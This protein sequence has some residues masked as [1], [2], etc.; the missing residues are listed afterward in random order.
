MKNP[1]PPKTKIIAVQEA[2][3][4]LSGILD[5]EPTD[6]ELAQETG[7][8]K[9][10]IG[11]LLGFKVADESEENNGE[12]QLRYKLTIKNHELEK[13]RAARGLKQDEVAQK[14]GISGA[15]Y[16]QIECCRSYPTEHIR[17]LISS[18]F[19][20][21]VKKLFP[22]WLEIYS[23]KWNTVEKSKIVPVSMIPISSPEAL[24]LP[25]GDDTEMVR[26]ADNAFMKVQIEKTMN[27]VLAPK[28]R[29]VVELRNKGE[30]LEEVGKVI[31]VTRERVRQIEAKAHE[32]LRQSD[33]F[34]KLAEE[35][36]KCK[37]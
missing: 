6:D 17:V 14:V 22:E 29:T 11:G 2:Y 34:K 20:M 23:Q 19:K 12:F 30:N 28:E 24:F 16:S 25:S 1:Y 15:F 21:P 8:D 36:K 27:E 31:G 4:C 33:Y 32:K 26:S 13:A 37:N 10:E 5:R 3:E 7:F 9:R 18:F 35:I